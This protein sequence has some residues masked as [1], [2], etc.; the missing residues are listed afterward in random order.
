M[1]NKKNQKTEVDLFIDFPHSAVS[2]EFLLVSIKSKQKDAL[3]GCIW[4]ELPDIDVN[5]DDFYTKIGNIIDEIESRCLITFSN[6]V[7]KE[8]KLIDLE[9]IQINNYCNFITSFKNLAEKTLRE[10]ILHKYDS[11]RKFNLT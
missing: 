11:V 4:I 2:E 7:M 6:C 10:I 5:E 3:N 1:K 8:S 9:N